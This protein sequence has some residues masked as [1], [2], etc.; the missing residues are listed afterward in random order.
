M[1]IS[2]IIVDDEPF[3]G[4]LLEEYVAQVPFLKLRQKC[5][6]GIEALSYLREHQVDLI[7]LDIN[8]KY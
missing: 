3:A 2:C 8:L 1:T 4:N 5:L 6:T 7:F